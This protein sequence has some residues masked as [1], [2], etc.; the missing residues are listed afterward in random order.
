MYCARRAVKGALRAPLRGRRPL[1][2]RRAPRL[3]FTAAA[4][5]AADSRK[6]ENS[7]SRL[8]GLILCAALL[9]AAAPAQLQPYSPSKQKQSSSSSDIA[10]GMSP[11]RLAR[12]DAVVE[13][14]IR[15]KECSGA[16]VLV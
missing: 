1:T 3:P 11:S 5:A 14:S 10:Q 15:S 4:N 16:V 8:A 12:I 6:S 2:A 7:F 13:D 9:P